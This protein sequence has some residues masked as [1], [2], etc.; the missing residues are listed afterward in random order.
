MAAKADTPGRD[1]TSHG[2]ESEERDAARKR[3][4]EL[5]A[6]GQGGHDPE[7]GRADP[8]L[9]HHAF[10]ALAENVRDYAV[11]LMD[12]QGIIR[13]W[14]AGAHLMKRWTKEEAEGGHLRMLYPDGGAED[15]TAEAHLRAAARDGEYVG[16]G[17]RV[18]ADGT[19]F[20]ARVTLTALKNPEGELLGFGKV[21]IDLTEQRAKDG[22][23]ALAREV[24]AHQEAEARGQALSAEVE[25]L[26]EEN[27]FLTKELHERDKTPEQ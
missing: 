25:V 9:V 4:R 24:T 8:E 5:R 18:R 7:V 15:G 3:G 23:R 11:F 17:H 27:S 16:E 19:T 26:E 2:K 22:S 1:L 10:A 13:F 14:G 20:W 12:V 6:A 21:T